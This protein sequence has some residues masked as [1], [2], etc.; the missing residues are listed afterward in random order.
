[1]NTI[2]NYIDQGGVIMY[3]LLALNILGFSV[4]IYKFFRILFAKSKLN[5][6]SNQI[7]NK[8]ASNN[9]SLSL[10]LAKD[11]IS[12]SML[13]LESGLGIVKSIASIAPLLGLLGTVI[14]VLISF[15]SISKAG[16][17][18]PAVFAGGISLAL[19]TTV[20][21]L[22]VAIPHYIGYNFL[23]GMLDRFEARLIKD[24]GESL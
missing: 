6:L 21:G 24:T 16:M 10:Q 12:S 15:E 7:A 3:I 17:D 23:I 1:M 20:A 2:M 18:D 9:R 11:E 14:G 8:V 22:I 5:K 19:V 13:S 4:M